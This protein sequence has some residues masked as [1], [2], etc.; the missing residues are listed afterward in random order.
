MSK[1]PQ[2]GGVDRPLAVRA[3][4]PQLRNATGPADQ[5]SGKWKSLPCAAI[6]LGKRDVNH[7]VAVA[8]GD[9]VGDAFDCSGCIIVSRREAYIARKIVRP[10]RAI[11]RPTKTPVRN[12]VIF[13]H[14]LIAFLCLMLPPER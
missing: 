8:V 2:K 9:G 4:N 10:R 6:K 12:P 7:G 1:L 3:K 14:R 13:P 5:A 11:V